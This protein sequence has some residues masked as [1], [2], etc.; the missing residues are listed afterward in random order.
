MVRR[1]DRDPSDWV[2]LYY[3]GHA[4]V[5]GT[6]SLYLLTTDFVPF[7]YV[8]TAFDLR[9]IADMLLARLDDKRARRVRNLLVIVDTCF[10][11]QGTAELARELA[12]AFRRSSGQSFYLLGAALPRQVAKAGALARALI[13]ALEEFSGRYVMQE[14]LYLEQIVPEVNRRLGTVHNAM[15]SAVDSASEAPRFFPNPAFVPLSIGAVPANAALRAITDE[16][17]RTHWSPRARGVEFEEQA[18]HY[19]RGRES[20][21]RNL[22]AFLGSSTDSKTRIVTGRPGAG[23]SAILG[24]LVTA[25]EVGDGEFPPVD[26]AIHAKGKSANQVA[27][28]MAGL[29]NVEANEESILTGFRRLEDPGP[30][31]SRRSG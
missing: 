22:T 25:A 21:L 7:Q 9:Q 28:R 3:T 6:D 10:A 2:V 30:H 18:G 14:W 31:R 8:G 29:L 17:F 19:F 23:K 15:W 27:Q 11:G 13:A 12:T 24:R 16:E 20:V 4:E 26:L 1:A 5:V